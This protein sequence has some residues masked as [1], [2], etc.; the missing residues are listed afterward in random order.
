MPVSLNSVWRGAGRVSA[1]RYGFVLFLVLAVLAGAAQPALAQPST[2]SSDGYFN[3][4]AQQQFLQSL[5]ADMQ[6]R[7]VQLKS[8]V[9]VTGTDGEVSATPTAKH[10]LLKT[11]QV[12]S[13]EDMAYLDAHGIDVVHFLGENVY[14]AY[15]LPA[16]LT[17]LTSDPLIAGVAAIRPEDKLPAEVCHTLYATT[18]A[19]DAALD[20]PALGEARTYSILLF[21]GTD[22]ATC[23]ADLAAQGISAETYDWGTATALQAELTP[24]QAMAVAELDD[25]YHVGRADLPLVVENLNSRAYV[26]A[27]E[28]ELYPYRLTGLGVRVLVR[29]ED[30]PYHAVYATRLRRLEVLSPA[31]PSF[32]HTHVTGT[33]LA[34]GAVAPGMAR[35]AI[36][37]SS[38]F[39][40]EITAQEGAAEIRDA[41]LNYG[42]QLSNHSYGLIAAPP[43]VYGEDASQWDALVRTYGLIIVK[44]AGNTRNAP[45]V[46]TYTSLW[47]AS[48]AKN[49]IV[50]GAVD[51]DDTMSTFSSF[52]PTS[53]GRIKPDVVADGVDVLSTFPGN[54]YG[55]FSGTS[56]AAPATTGVLAQFIEQYRR[57][58][59]AGASPRPDIAR[60]CLIHG[61]RD[62]VPGDG[63]PGGPGPFYTVGPDY[64]SGFGTVDSINAIT[65]LNG[66]TS[67]DLDQSQTFSFPFVVSQPTLQLKA[68]LVWTD[69]PGSLIAANAIITDLDLDLTSPSSTTFFPWSLNPASPAS[70]ATAVGPNTVD[71]VEQVVVPNP[72][73][74]V[75]TVNVTGTN[76]P[77]PLQQFAVVVSVVP[78]ASGVDITTSLPS[79]TRAGPI[80]TVT[81][82]GRGGS[83]DYEYQ[84]V[85]TGPSTGGSP[86]IVQAYSPDNTWDFDTMSGVG[87]YDI[88][89]QVRNQGS[90][91]D[92]EAQSS[93]AYVINAPLPIASVSLAPDLASP[94]PVS[95]MI[96]WTG[97]ATGGTGDYL[98]EFS[99]YGPSTG[100]VWSIMQPFSSTNTFLW[101]T[102]GS[103]GIHWVRVRSKN[104][105]SPYLYERLAYSRFDVTPLQ[106]S[107][108]ANPPSPQVAGTPA[109][110]NDITVTAGASGGTGSYEFQ[111]WLYGFSTGY[112][113]QMVQDFG[114]GPSFVWDTT[115]TAGRHW[116]R[117]FARNAGSAAQNEGFVYLPFDVLAVRPPARP[118]VSVLPPSPQLAGTQITFSASTTGGVGVYEW[119]FEL[120]GPDTGFTWVIQQPYGGGS[121]W[122][123]NTVGVTPGTYWT[124]VSVRN[125][126]ST[127][128]VEN[129]NYGRMVLTGT[130]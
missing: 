89:V 120:Y 52:G 38:S 34:A 28:A 31:A 97:Q 5:P 98:Y 60:A 39:A 109:V 43:G 124:R 68:T 41:F 110:P 35:R 61:A 79:G 40:N 130:P 30:W 101:D 18:T 99:V 62:L 125:L 81:A 9:V 103:T 70:P 107:A 16:A 22:P 8:R 112:T 20:A 14:V 114:G 113:W 83:G 74:G 76:V 21:P 72:Q 46:G 93:R 123:W 95:T 17:T 57:T 129:L 80:V 56:M 12:L 94:R 102:S 66:L 36:A 37:I 67:G 47:G 23:V 65:A 58:V 92:P 13:P 4:T 100:Y 91:A 55:V 121:T 33:V 29:D 119:Q 115:G 25:V 44:S 96:T 6:Q 73:L 3:N 127:A 87:T 63:A 126:G 122:V 19:E 108:L 32:H 90:P 111:F 51:H 27:D 49:V 71:T 84:F 106:V 69:Q 82:E 117:I 75:W 42:A 24:E 116:F 2:I 15:C 1:A 53:D 88:T 59:G 11:T 85:L 78:P 54:T 48:T 128:P 26:R 86:T 118:V 7:A 105:L 50:V 77:Q 104:S 45:G 10:V 64:A